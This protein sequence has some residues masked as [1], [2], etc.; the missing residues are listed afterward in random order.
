VPDESGATPTSLLVFAALLAVAVGGDFLPMGRFLVPVFAPLALLGGGVLARLAGRRRALA[1]AVG[2]ALCA[3]GLLPAF[4]LAPTPRAWRE[5][6][7]HQWSRARRLDELETWR[8]ARDRARDDER[9]AAA[10]ALHTRAGESLVRDAIGVVG[11]RTELVLLD[12]FGLVDREVARLPL[13]GERT[14]PGHDRFVSTR[15]F[16]HREPDYLD[17][18][19][20]PAGVPPAVGVDS[21]L[22]DLF[23]AGRAVVE[24]FPAGEGLDLR[25]L[26]YRPH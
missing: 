8:R 18:W 25:L 1:L 7:D 14:S 3:L 22:A 4:G 6:L 13:S 17:A 20:V 10:L 16:L 2:A 23:E 11:Y 21:A 15:W 9:L 19:L 24:S 26:R 5:A 12:R